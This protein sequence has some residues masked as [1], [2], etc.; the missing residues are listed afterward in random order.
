MFIAAASASMYGYNTFCA[1]CLAG[2]NIDKKN[3]IKAG[4]SMVP[5]WPTLADI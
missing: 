5:V 3:E 4:K 1:L 2:K